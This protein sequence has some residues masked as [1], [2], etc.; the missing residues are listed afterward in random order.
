MAAYLA[1][2]SSDRK[3]VADLHRLRSDAFSEDPPDPDTVVALDSVLRAA[4]VAAPTADA[5][6]AAANTASFLEDQ[7]ESVY[8]S[9]LPK[10]LPDE[11]PVAAAPADA[12][13]PPATPPTEP[14][15]P[16]AT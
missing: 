4:E 2:P 6:A 12:T 15:A 10:P 5:K 7:P 16:V 8:G 11:A 13:E 3:T 14:V 1:T 9:Q